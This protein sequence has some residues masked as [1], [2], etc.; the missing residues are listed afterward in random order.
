[1]TDLTDWHRSCTLNWCSIYIQRC[2]GMRVATDGDDKRTHL[3]SCR[4]LISFI[5]ATRR[6]TY[7]WCA[8]S[9]N[10]DIVEDK[11]EGD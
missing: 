11:F 6:P 2:N 9:L 3:P 7:S 1:M 10:K 5:Q 4:L 8:R